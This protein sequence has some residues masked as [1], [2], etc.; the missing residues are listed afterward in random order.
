MAIEKVE[1]KK[2]SNYL[3]NK[4][5]MAE[6]KVS[7]KQ[8][9]MTDRLAKMLMMLCDRYAK[10]PN[11]AGYTFVDDMQA[12]A[13]FML[14]RTWDSFDPKKSDNP[15]AY[16]TQCIKNSFRQYL[17]NE[18][19]QR[20]IRDELLIDCGLNPSYN[21]G[22]DDHSGFEQPVVAPSQEFHDQHNEE[23]TVEEN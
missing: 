19:K 6:I 14:V 9:K 10:R 2:K 3:N 23:S 12:Y 18:K 17:K 1:V 15:F 13:L 16:F 7:K 8:K 21:Y 4:D 11:Y 22:D 5:L 20:D